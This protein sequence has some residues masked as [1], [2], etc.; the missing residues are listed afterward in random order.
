MSP[1]L[2][3]QLVPTNYDDYSLEEQNGLATILYT[4]KVI[5][6][7]LTLHIVFGAIMGLMAGIFLHDEYEKVPR[8]RGIF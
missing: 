4:S 8:K 1:I 5:S 7:A 6:I 2:E 3:V